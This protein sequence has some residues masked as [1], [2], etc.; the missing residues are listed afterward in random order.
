[1]NYF[2]G[3]LKISCPWTLWLFFMVELIFFEGQVSKDDS[4]INR[5]AWGN[6]LRSS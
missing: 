4:I 2:K 3:S 6:A 1:M 5:F